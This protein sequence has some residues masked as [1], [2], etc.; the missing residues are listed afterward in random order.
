MSEGAQVAGRLGESDH[1]RLARAVLPPLAMMFVG[2]LVFL[3]GLG[4]N[5]IAGAVLAPALVLLRPREVWG[6]FRLILAMMLVFLLTGLAAQLVVGNVSLHQLALGVLR[7]VN[8]GL[9]GLVAYEFHDPV[10]TAR[11]LCRLSPRLPL[12]YLSSLRMLVLAQRSM[13]EIL[14]VARVNTPESQNGLGGMLLQ[15]RLLV[16]AL[17]NSL[18][19]SSLMAAEAEYLRSGRVCIGR[20]GAQ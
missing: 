8:L 5:L 2:T 17:A 6:A 11:L 10:Y 3:G 7:L 12:Y 20:E 16:R 1:D 14:G 4:V 15:A 18:L 9:A 19:E 13:G